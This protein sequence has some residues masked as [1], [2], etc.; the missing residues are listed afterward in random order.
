MGVTGIPL[1]ETGRIKT[2]SPSPAVPRRDLSP[3]RGEVENPPF[4]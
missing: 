2:K 3:K 4:L 1:V